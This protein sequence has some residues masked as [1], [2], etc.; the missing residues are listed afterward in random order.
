V[1]SQ[2]A[3]AAPASAEDAVEWLLASVLRERVQPIEQKA[4]LCKRNSREAAD[5]MGEKRMCIVIHTSA[6]EHSQKTFVGLHGNFGK[7]S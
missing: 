4:A 3:A 7:V 1:T 6:A 5:E 2:T